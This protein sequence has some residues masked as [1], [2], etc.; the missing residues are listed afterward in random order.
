MTHEVFFSEP[1]SLLAINLQLPTQFNFSA[2]SL[3]GWRLETRL[4]LLNWT[5]LYNH[6]A[7]TTQKTTYYYE[8][9]FAARRCI[10]T[11]A[12]R[13]FLTYWLPREYIYRVVAS[14]ERLF[15][16]HFSG[17]RASCHNINLQRIITLHN[18]WFSWIQITRESNVLL[19]GKPG[20]WGRALFHG[21]RRLTSY[22][23][24]LGHIN[25]N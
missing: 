1:N 17:F 12:T 11:E 22:M 16:L 3:A 2:H 13:F 4:T 10:A 25:V 5:L 19:H 24:N 18:Q 9:V 20:F 14:S 15:W 23:C 21:F 6:F 7:R 8:D